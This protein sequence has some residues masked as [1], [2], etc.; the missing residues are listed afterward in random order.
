LQHKADDEFNCLAQ[1]IN[2]QIS[3]TF[4]HVI[5]SLF[6][7]LLTLALNGLIKINILFRKEMRYMKFTRLQIQKETN[8]INKLV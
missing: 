5:A 1:K 4:Y 8:K 3:K 6:Q 7:K 2:Y